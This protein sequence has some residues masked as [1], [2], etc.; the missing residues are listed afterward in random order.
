MDCPFCA[1]VAGDAPASVVHADDTAVAFL[2]IEPANPGH[3]LVVPRDHADGLGD[4]PAE[5]G[6]HMF[7]VAQRVAAALRASVDADGIGLLLADGAAAGQEVFHV[8]LHVIPRHEGD[9]VVFRGNQT[10]ADRDDLD[11]L[12]SRVRDHL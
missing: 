7:G 2:D 4:L 6:G 1:I 12:A 5:T 8:H 11:E 10:P 9:G 3:T